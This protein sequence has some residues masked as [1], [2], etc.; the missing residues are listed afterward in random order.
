MEEKVKLEEEELEAVEDMEEVVEDQGEEEEINLVKASGVMIMIAE[1]MTV[2]RLIL[3]GVETGDGRVK[4]E[5]EDPEEALEVEQEVT[6][7]LGRKERR[8]SSKTSGGML[9]VTKEDQESIH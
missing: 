6:I 8:V 5:E 3:E 1:T 9:T 7:E 4:R 2:G